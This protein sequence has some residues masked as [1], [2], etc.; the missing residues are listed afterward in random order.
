[1]ANPK[2]HV[3]SLGD[4][5]RYPH[6]K[7]TR[8]KFPRLLATRKI[9]DDGAEYFGAFL[10]ET[11]VRLLM[12]FLNKIFRLR[13]C[14]IEIDGNYNVPC[15]QFYRKRCLAPCVESLCDAENYGKEVDL[16]RLFLQGK[17]KEL[18]KH[19]LKK[20]ERFSKALNFEAAKEQSD[21]WQLIKKHFADKD[22]NFRLD[23]ATDTFTLS[24]TKEGFLLYLVTMRG[25]RTLGKRIY[26]FPKK[27]RIEDILSTVIP[28]FYCFHAPRKIR[29]SHDFP[30]RL[31]VANRLSLKLGRKITIEIIKKDHPKIMTD[32]AIRRTKFEYEFRQISL[33]KPLPEIQK[34]LKKDFQ[35]KKKPERI[36]AFDVAHISGSNFVAAKSVWEKGKFIGREDEFWFSDEESELETLRKFIQFRFGR[37][38]TNWPDLILIDGGKSHLNAALRAVEKLLA[39]KFSIVSAVKPPRQHREIS[40]FLNEN[41]TRTKFSHEKPSH[42]VLQNLRDE[43][44]YLSNEIHRQR[45]ELTHYYKLAQI[46]PSLNEGERRELLL[47]AGSLQNLTNLQ[48][49][50]LE[51]IFSVEKA[52]RILL[53]LEN[54]RDGRSLQVEPLI[55]PLRYTDENGDAADLRPIVNFHVKCSLMASKKN[56]QLGARQ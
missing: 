51:R 18:E 42:Y 29:I 24:D 54:F 50:H 55:V 30:G 48:R 40:H 6:F 22:W 32:R 15:P 43:A 45:R 33:E 25:R 13:T 47:H 9:A 31:V 2:K 10:P 38:P 12:D 52:G 44:H 1:M 19:F 37:Q 26:V 20:I 27:G 21:R 11:G 53:D 3:F 36:E 41:G 17:E 14:E 49:D 8:E 56:A 5:R 39:R 4:K 35:L 46:L 34:E 23:A 7:L 28:E 16:V